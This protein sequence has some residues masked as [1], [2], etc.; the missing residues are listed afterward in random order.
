MMEEKLS[1]E[2]VSHMIDKIT[3]RQ[4]K[5]FVQLKDIFMQ[6]SLYIYV[7]F[8]VQDMCSTPD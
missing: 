5:L 1:D 4:T 7:H 8:F 3:S 2:K 6:M